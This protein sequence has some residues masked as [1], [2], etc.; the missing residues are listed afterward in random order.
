MNW[1]TIEYL[2]LGTERQQA[3]YLCLSR[4]NILGML[5][6]FDPVL[7][8]TVCIDIDVPTSDLDVICY[9]P[10][11]ALFE[12][13]LKSLFQKYPAFRL[14]HS[15]DPFS[16]V[17]CSFFLEPFEIEIF[18]CDVPV[19][20][21]AAYRHLTAISRLLSSPKGEWLREE[22]RSLKCSG[23]KTEPAVAKLL[24]LTGDPYEAVLKLN[25]V[26]DDELRRLVQNAYAQ[27][28]DS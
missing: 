25:G 28:R 10:E 20:E 19:E 17:V 27:G 5:S 13:T 6:Q 7:V 16:S 24:G 21:Q 11:R 1:R 18:G 8:S 15:E 22:I 14:L 23:V 4:Y 3:A 9:A 26:E 2:R 12:E